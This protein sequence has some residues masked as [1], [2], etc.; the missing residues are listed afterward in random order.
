MTE[1]IICAVNNNFGTAYTYYSLLCM[2]RDKL[3]VFTDYFF[4]VLSYVN[5][6]IMLSGYE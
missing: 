2:S 1:D 5:F 6:V 4:H 3:L